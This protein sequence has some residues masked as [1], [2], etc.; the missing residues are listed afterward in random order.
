MR[1]E[2]RG[3]LYVKNNRYYIRVHYYVNG[4]RKSKDVATGIS[5]GTPGSRKGKQAEKAAYQKLAEIVASFEIPG[6]PKSENKKDQMFEETIREWL[7]HQHMGKAPSTMA[8][9]QC[10]AKDVILYFSELHPM[11]TVDMTSNMIEQYQ[12]WERMRRSP[13]YEGEHRAKR[14]HCDGSGIENT[15]K[16]RTTLIRSVLQYAKREGIVERNV[17]STRDSQINLPN[18]Q[19]HEFS[20]LTQEEGKWLLA[21]VRNEDLWFATAVTMGLLWGLRRSEILGLR[22]S[23]IDWKTGGVTI[24]HTVTQQTMD[25]KRTITP[26]TTSKNKRIRSFAK[27]QPITGMLKKLVAENMK[28]AEL[29]G[30]VYDKTWD[31]YMFRYPDGKLIPPDAL[32]KKFTTFLKANN[33]RKIR[34]HDLRHSCAS[35]LLAEGVDLATIQE[36]LGHAQISTTRIYLHIA[37]EAKN[38]ALQQ[39]GM[40]LIGDFDMEE[41]E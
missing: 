9:Y 13:G 7:V 3:N 32:T 8:S 38:N 18:P 11:R 40:Q 34:F 12:N 6:E 33:M 23:D 28:N 37:N 29:F 4:V 22:V 36:I 26:K 41:E 30:D 27:M 35:F 24:R 39:M 17:A 31:G 1:K 21:E 25:G 20:V 5:V 19:G 15:V 16:H 14:V 2:P 10:I